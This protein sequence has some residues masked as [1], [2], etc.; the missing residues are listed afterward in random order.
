MNVE[1]LSDTIGAHFSSRVEAVLGDYVRVT[2]CDYDI[3]KDVCRLWTSTVAGDVGQSMHAL[4]VKIRTRTRVNAVSI[5]ACKK[6]GLRV[7]LHGCMSE[8]KRWS[9]SQLR[10]RNT[11]RLVYFLFG[12]LAAVV[13]YL[14]YR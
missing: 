7:E 11:E 5:F 14:F 2:E 6:G 4:E 3:N 12:L 9:R 10:I 1:L 8:Y 13:F